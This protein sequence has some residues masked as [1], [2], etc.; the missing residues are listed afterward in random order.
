M[1]NYREPE[2]TE[3]DP[4]SQKKGKKITKQYGNRLDSWA[5]F[6]NALG[7]FSSKL[8]WSIIGIIIVATLGRHLYV[9][10]QGQSYQQ[11]RLNTE[12][13]IQKPIPW[14]KINK[15]IRNALQTST[16]TARK[17]ATDELSKWTSELKYRI[18]ENFL[19][20]YFSYWQQ[21][22]MGLKAMGYWIADH[23]LVEKIFGE[24]PSMAERITEEIQTEFSK[25]VLR[26]QIAQLRI[27]RIANNTV[28]VYVKELSKYLSDIPN[29]YHLSKADWERYLNNI[30]LL[31]NKV[32]GDRQISVTLKALTVSGL[33]GST[34]AAAKITKML[35]PMITTI[36]TKV[37]TKAAAKGAGKVAVKV[38]SKTGAKVGAEVGGKFL[39]AIVGVGVIAWDVWDHHNTKKIEKPILRKNLIDYLTELQ[40]KLL[41]DSKTGLM[42]IIH[43]LN[44]NVVDQM[45]RQKTRGESGLVSQ[46]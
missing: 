4:T 46:T 29:K 6:L 5:R 25:R 27:E 3:P 14:Q 40:H 45:P 24:Q 33:A 41:D 44:A 9:K 13:P 7:N 12:I 18:D 38:A 34:V 42:A 32:E 8:I 2:Q 11:N 10:S 28:Q 23:K 37:T 26:P 1:E 21:Q 30:A 22:W 36:G 17:Y 35:K 19:N 16:N 15:D 31:T 39:G 20:W 43:Q